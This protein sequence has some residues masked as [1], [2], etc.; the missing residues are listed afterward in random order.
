MK[1]PAFNQETSPVMP[2][3]AIPRHYF[4]EPQ[5]WAFDACRAR[6][7]LVHG[8]MLV[9]WCR[10]EPTISRQRSQRMAILHPAADVSVIYARGEAA[11]NHNT[12]RRL[13]PVS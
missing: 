12:P 5:S 4:G 10:V 1:G 6:V 11:L 13:V 8:N 2:D 3:E 9:M 7:W